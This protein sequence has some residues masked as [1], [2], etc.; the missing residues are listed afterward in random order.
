MIRFVD[1]GTQINCYPGG[2]PVF[3]WYDTIH[4]TFIQID[5]EETWESWDAFVVCITNWCYSVNMTPTEYAATMERYT[6]LFPETWPMYR[7]QQ[8]REQEN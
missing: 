3:A 1:I 5:G 7:L 4:D 6:R 2:V 8:Y